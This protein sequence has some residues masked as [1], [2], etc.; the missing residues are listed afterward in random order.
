MT[1]GS[2]YSGCGGIDA[3]LEAAG[4]TCRWQVEKNRAAVKIL[5]RHW[6]D[7]RRHGDSTTLD[8]AVL[9]RVDLI[10]GGDPCPKRSRARTIHGADAPDLWPDFLRFVSALRPL[11]VLREHV[12]SSDA[13]Q[14]WTDLCRL[15]Y[16]AVI[17]DCDSA[18]VTGQ[19][20]AREYLFGVLESSGVCP[21]RVLSQPQGGRRVATAVGAA[22]SFARCLTTHDQRFDS[23]DNYVLEPGRGVR[24]LDSEE[25]ERLQGLQPGWTA[26]LP[27]RTRARLTGNAATVPLVAHLGRLIL[28]ASA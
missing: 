12:V 26:G 22:G 5:E 17:L 13:D 4:M 16:V 10:A 11:W 6:P 7:V 28:E 23:R 27:R 19:S 8:P 9:E 18:E 20:R 25:R 3:G 15:G 21:G 1:F 14:C 2:L 24:V